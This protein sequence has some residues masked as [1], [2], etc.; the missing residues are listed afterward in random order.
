MNLDQLLNSA[1]GTL[2]SYEAPPGID[3]AWAH[4]LTSWLAVDVAASRGHDMKPAVHT[5]RELSLI[6]GARC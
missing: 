3:Q 1:F 4:Q 2:V 5:P 6:S